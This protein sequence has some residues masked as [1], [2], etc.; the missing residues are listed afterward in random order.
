MILFAWLVFNNRNLSWDNLRKRRWHGP[1]RCFMC[2]S[3]EETNL[4]MFFQ[5]NTTQ[6]I[7]YE[8]A[9]SFDFPYNVFDS[10]H[11]AFKWWC[12]QCA[13]RRPI[14]IITLWL[15]WKW[16]NQK[17]FRDS[18]VPFSDIMQSICSSFDAITGS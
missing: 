13:K 1:N 10:V 18:K 3:E 4:H 14:L 12:S 7:W 15:A 9:I 5:C 17:I 16:R 2:E 8:L 11:A 6:K